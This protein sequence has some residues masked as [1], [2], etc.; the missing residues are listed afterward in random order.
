MATREKRPAHL[1]VGEYWCLV[2]DEETRDDLGGVL[3]TCC[4]N[5]EGAAVGAASYAARD[6]QDTEYDQ[7]RI[8]VEGPHRR[9]EFIVARHC[10]WRVKETSDDCRELF[11]RRVLRCS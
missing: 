9:Y 5:P 8:V 3:V 11:R 10:E 2:F 7:L 6:P 4:H 1:K